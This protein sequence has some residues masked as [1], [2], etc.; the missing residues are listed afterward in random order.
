M[1][2]ALPAIALLAPVVSS[3]NL[4]QLNFNRNLQADD[5]EV[6]N[7]SNGC[8][9]AG[10]ALFSTDELSSALEEV[11]VATVIEMSAIPYQLTIDGTTEESKAYALLC[12]SKSGRVYT[13]DMTFSGDCVEIF[14]FDFIDLP[15]CLPPIPTCT[16][17]E[18][19]EILSFMFRGDA[20]CIVAIDVHR[21]PSSAPSSSMG[22]IAKNKKSSAKNGKKAK[23]NNAKK[24]KKNKSSKKS[25][26]KRV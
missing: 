5:G 26:G 1:K 8:L 22:K 3:I 14:P 24:G 6:P 2:L 18:V 10:A 16:Y 20:Q 23:A 19:R 15:V 11:I 7:V 12:E 21:A 13:A 4:G 9:M 25:K 17:D